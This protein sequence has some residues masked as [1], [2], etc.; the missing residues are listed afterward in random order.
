MRPDGQQFLDVLAAFPPDTFENDFSKTSTRLGLG[1]VLA[2]ED[3]TLLFE[4]AFRA[5][6]CNIALNGLGGCGGRIDPAGE[7]NRTRLE[8]AFMAARGAFWACPGGRNLNP[9]KKK[10]IQ[11]IFLR[12]EVRQENLLS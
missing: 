5:G 7:S 12:V 6:F 3:L 1:E 2:P 11:R 8:R 10:E 9:V 4:A